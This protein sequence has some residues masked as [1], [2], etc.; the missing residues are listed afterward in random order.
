MPFGDSATQPEPSQLLQHDVLRRGEGKGQVWP[1]LDFLSAREL[2]TAERIVA[3]QVDVDLEAVAQV[4]DVERGAPPDAVADALLVEVE[5]GAERGGKARD[6]ASGEVGHE[7]DA[8]RRT[9]NPL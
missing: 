9:G 1:E 7:V 6:T 5:I 8:L 3:R 2:A 4:D